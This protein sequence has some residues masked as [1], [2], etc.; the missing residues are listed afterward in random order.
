MYG[1]QWSNKF[2]SKPSEL[3]SEAISKLSDDQIGIGLH[4]CVKTYRDFP[5]SVHGFVACATQSIDN[6]ARTNLSVSNTDEQLNASRQL[7]IAAPNTPN[8]PDECRE[9]LRTM[10]G[11]EKR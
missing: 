1:S 9:L 3:W 11:I 6:I 2:G 4:E 5:P 10:L 7:A 8:T